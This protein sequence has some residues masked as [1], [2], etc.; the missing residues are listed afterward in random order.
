MTFGIDDHDTFD[1]PTKEENIQNGVLCSCPPCTPCYIATVILRD[2][3]E[4][5]IRV[6]V[7]NRL[8]LC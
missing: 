3:G 7:C 5:Q 8:V 6:T 1:Y 2:D 4:E